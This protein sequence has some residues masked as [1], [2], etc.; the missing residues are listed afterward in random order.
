MST[1][2]L[3]R[4]ILLNLSLRFG[5]VLFIQNEITFLSLVVLFWWAIDNFNG[6]TRDK[7][8]KNI[9]HAFFLV[10]KIID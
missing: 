8:S 2:Q 5:Y 4:A 1:D 3:F 10:I 7:E 6:D 9:P